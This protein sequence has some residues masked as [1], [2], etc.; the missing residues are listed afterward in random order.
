MQGG[1]QKDSRKQGTLT[2]PA[3]AAARQP[4][5]H[6]ESSSTR[7]LTEALEAP[8]TPLPHRH[9]LPPIPGAGPRGPPP[10]GHTSPPRERDSQRSTQAVT[11]QQTVRPAPP[12]PPSGAWRPVHYRGDGTPR[13]RDQGDPQPT[14]GLN[15]GWGDDPLKAPCRKQGLTAPAPDTGTGQPTNRAHAPRGSPPWLRRGQAT[16]ARRTHHNNRGTTQATKERTK[17]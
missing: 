16:G 7:V 3:A 8:K 15:R 9:H 17:K 13:T 1:R 11:R 10:S 2:H 14:S 12:P 6:G 4:P 5:Q